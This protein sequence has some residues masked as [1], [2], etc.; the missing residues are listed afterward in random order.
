MS[1]DSA[2]AFFFYNALLNPNVTAMQPPTYAYI[3]TL[4]SGAYG[5]VLVCQQQPSGRLVAVGWVATHAIAKGRVAVS[6][7]A[8]CVESPLPPLP[9]VRNLA[10][11]V[12]GLPLWA[13]D[14]AR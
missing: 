1:S 10:N 7:T 9:P 6:S 3:S 2:L 5:T 11:S 14:E 8:R 12:A 13:A 4:S